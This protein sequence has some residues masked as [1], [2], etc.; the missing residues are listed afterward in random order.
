MARSRWRRGLGKGSNV[1]TVINEKSSPHD[2]L[3]LVPLASLRLPRGNQKFKL[4]LWPL[5]EERINT[6]RTRRI[7]R[8]RQQA[9]SSLYLYL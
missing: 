4:V 5:R 6:L 9:G 1:G 2:F 7:R 8:S 3:Y